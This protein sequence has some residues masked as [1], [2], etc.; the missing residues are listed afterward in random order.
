MEKTIILPKDIEILKKRTNQNTQVALLRKST[1]SFT[2]LSKPN[3]FKDEINRLIFTGS[4]AVTNASIIK[5]LITGLK[6]SYKKT[7]EL[8]GIGYKADIIKDKLLL[9]V[10]FSHGVELQIPQQLHISIEKSKTLVLKSIN[11]NLLTQFCSSLR[12]IKK[13]DTYKGKGFRFRN[14]LLIFKEGKKKK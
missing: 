6:K 7:M 9:T 13:P 3:F 14:E 1:V 2:L 10:G 4:T 8:H 5:N 11:L 12:K